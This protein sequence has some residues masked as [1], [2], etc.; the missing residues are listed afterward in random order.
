MREMYRATFGDESVLFLI[1]RVLQVWEA[2]TIMHLSN[3]PEEQRRSSDEHFLINLTSPWPY[4]FVAWGTV[5]FLLLL[6]ASFSYVFWFQ[7]RELACLFTSLAYVCCREGKR[8]GILI[9]RSSLYTNYT[10]RAINKIKAKLPKPFY[11]HV[12]YR[13]H[14]KKHPT[15]KFQLPCLP[16]CPTSS[17]VLSISS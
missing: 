4:L 11:M 13:P 14:K 8:K 3:I 9:T 5:F 10:E 17:C 12:E 15:S 16:N 7:E 1:W 6:C 2:G